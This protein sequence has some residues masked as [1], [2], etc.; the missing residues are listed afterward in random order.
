VAFA[1]EGDNFGDRPY[2]HQGED[3]APMGLKVSGLKP[4]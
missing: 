1:R 4:E 2:R 3:T